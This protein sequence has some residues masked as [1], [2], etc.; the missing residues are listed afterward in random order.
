LRSSS[1]GKKIG[2]PPG[3]NAPKRNQMQT[4]AIVKP[5]TDAKGRAVVGTLLAE[6]PPDLPCHCAKLLAH[7]PES[8]DDLRFGTI[9]VAIRQLREA[10]KP[11]APLTVR[12]E[13]QQT[14]RL[15]DAGGALF[16]D[17][18]G[19]QAVGVS[20]AEY[21]ATDLWEAYR[22]RRLKSVFGEA[23]AAMEADPTRADAIAAAVQHSIEALNKEHANGSRLTIR[24]PDE[25][26]AQPQDAHDNI[27]GDRLLAKGQSITLLGPG[28]I[29]KSRMLLQWAACSIV[30][31]SFIGLE[32]HGQNLRWLVFQVEN[33]N[34]RLQ[35][36]L[37]HLHA[38]FR[39]DWQT[40]N[41]RLA[42][43]TLETDRDG[44]LSL[45][46]EEN[47]FAIAEAIEANA[48]DVVVFDPLNQFAI[49]DPNKDQDM[50][51]TCQAITRLC[52]KGNP[53]R[54]IS[55]LHH[56][57]TG[58]A[59]AAKSFGMERVGY[60]RNSKVLQ[61]WT[62]GQINLAPISEDTNDLLAVLCGKCSNGKEFA[63]F[64]VRL[65]HDTMLYEV[66]PDVDMEAWR[67]DVAGSKSNGPTMTP[68]KVRELCLVSGMDKAQ[69]AKA[70]I[71]DCGCYRG[72]A[73]R[74]I[75][76]AEKAKQITLRKSDGQY[77]RK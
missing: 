58:R 57:I 40:I 24:T 35:M 13:L 51:A 5:D 22:T 19:F 30:G 8:F 6:F 56:T 55:I 37:N 23:F 32:T 49:G 25:I 15:D 53:Q 74:Y 42:I 14:N 28:G 21:E 47:Q 26:L 66:A 36:D 59:G 52:R 38:A 43:H 18:L 65:N 75:T 46:A 76:K 3:S 68:S 34:R 61:A 27:L 73:Y 2:A 10:G 50:A 67:A 4:C 64:A 29:G 44:W 48:P 77:F 9:V 60:G 54:A 72:S 12:E 16:L 11:I 7:A 45:D 71:E 20:I 63:P 69:L 39:N 70:I 17:T 33:A 62:R 31:K 41:A 1:W